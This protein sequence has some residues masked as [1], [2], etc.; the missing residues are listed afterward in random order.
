MS[1]APSV[2]SKLI[3][4]KMAEKK[5]DSDDGA[6]GPM[7][8]PDVDGTDRPTMHPKKMHEKMHPVKTRLTG[9]KTYANQV[10]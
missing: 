3:K 2:A 4:G 7:D 1:R 8:E 6:D 5:G 10:H 9:L